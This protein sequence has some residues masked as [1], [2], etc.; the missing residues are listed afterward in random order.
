MNILLIGNKET[1]KDPETYYGEYVSFF[2]EGIESA[3]R[4]SQI[5]FTLVDD[6]VISIGDGEF[7]IY[8][9]RHQTDINEYQL[10]L[11]R[12][13]GFRNMFDVMK[14]ISTYA[15]HN[16]IPVVND[17]SG[18][19]DSS[20]LTQATQFFELGLPVARSV[21]VTP[22]VLTGSIPLKFD[23]PCI[24]KAT[25]GAHGND[26][27]LVKDIQEVRRIAESSSDKHFV[28]QRFVPN[29]KDYRLL[30]IGSELLI[31]GREA[32]EGSHL[33][34]TSQGG[35]AVLASEG[36]VPQKIIN[37]SRKIMQYLG[38]SIAGVD[39][40]ADKVTG[41]FYFLEVNSQPQLM[42]GA[43][44]EEK[45]KAVGRYFDSLQS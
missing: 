23:Y 27:Y 22:A 1:A 41:E 36:D 37:D 45:S 6:L 38:M 29:D 21:Y 43:F 9:V 11:I 30:I 3:N 15:K 25:F 39:V 16:N 32:V 2:K 7:S 18:F 35:K 5:D 40:L 31:I 14:T 19:R 10:L 20:K 17:Y 34:N 13:K 44:I 33:N 24:M 42:S 12:G 28:L 8:D 26:N 4:K